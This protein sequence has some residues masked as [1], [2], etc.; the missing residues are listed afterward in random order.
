[1]V[2]PYIRCLAVVKSI[3]AP[4][5]SVSRQTPHIV[6]LPQSADGVLYEEEPWFQLTDETEDMSVH[7]IGTPRL[8]RLRVEV[9]RHWVLPAMISYRR[10]REGRTV[11]GTEDNIWPSE[12]C[13]YLVCGEGHDVCVLGGWELLVP[14]HGEALMSVHPE[15]IADTLRAAEQLK[16]LHNTA[17]CPFPWPTSRFLHQKAR[18]YL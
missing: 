8:G 13:E 14:V 12:A 15:S 17:I 11:V 16:N 9:S 3:A 10:H 2:R 7:G 18:M 5:S 6:H 4:C 1:M